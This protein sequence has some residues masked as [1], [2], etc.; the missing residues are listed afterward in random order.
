MQHLIPLVLILSG[1]AGNILDRA[2]NGYVIDFI[3]FHYDSKWDFPVFN[4]ADMLVFCGIVLLFIA[5]RLSGGSI[6]EKMA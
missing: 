3:H 4:I 6:A 1:A 5:N 2:M